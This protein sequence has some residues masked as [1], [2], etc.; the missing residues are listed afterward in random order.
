MINNLT[1][2]TPGSQIQHNV[3]SSDRAASSSFFTAA[4]P[5]DQPLPRVDSFNGFIRELAPGS[6]SLDYMILT[7]ALETTDDAQSTLKACSAP[8]VAGSGAELMTNAK[9]PPVESDHQNISNSPEAVKKHKS[10]DC[11]AVRLERNRRESAKC[12]E[13]KANDLE[14]PKKKPTL[15]EAKRLHAT[16]DEQ[17]TTLNKTNA[18]LKQNIKEMQ[19]ESDFLRRLIP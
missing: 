2:S 1:Q 8:S 6:E 10:G 17:L 11:I 15:R 14:L 9:R 4:K 18:E 7:R 16:L 19:A 5:V 13:S 3:P 12:N